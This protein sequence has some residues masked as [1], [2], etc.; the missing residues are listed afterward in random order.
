MIA[1]LP[2][3]L[4]EMLAVAPATFALLLA[5][6]G[7]GIVAA[8]VA[9]RRQRRRRPWQGWATRPELRRAGLLAPRGI[10]LGRWGRDGPLL[11]VGGSTH[12]FL[13]APTRAGKGAGFV[14]PNLLDWPGSVVVLDLKG[15][16]YAASAGFRA[17]HG[18]QLVLFD[19]ESPL[20]RR[21]N[22]LPVAADA[23]ARVRDLQR[24]A[25]SLYD[26]RAPAEAFWTHQARELFVGAALMALET[27]GEGASLGQ[28]QRFLATPDLAESIHQTLPPGGAGPVTEACARRLRQWADSG[29]ESMRAGILASAGERLQ[30]WSEPLLDRATAGSDFCLADLRRRPMAVYLRVAPA[31]L[32]RLAP[33]LRLFLDQLVH[34]NTGTPFGRETGNPV[35]VLLLLDEFPALGRVPAV[36]GAI[37]FMASFGLRCCLVAQS[38]SQL[39]GAYGE[40]GAAT[41]IRNCAS[42]IYLAPEG[43]EE[44][45]A[46]SA[47]LGSIRAPQETRTRPAAGLG[48]SSLSVTLVDRP[49]LPAHA[50]RAMARDAAILLVPGCRPIR[51][52]RIHWW[53]DDAFRRRRLPVPPRE[54]PAWRS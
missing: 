17:R 22:P 19:P 6:L 5:T 29:S 48:R 47:A 31:A 44:A 9:R 39:H 28:V 53:R 7:G 4:P 14:I 27:R 38:E 11:R 20:S 18:H 34:A 36:E 2:E 41:L 43:M 13:A 52:A 51:A 8:G 33:L 32:L 35:P 24:L 23:A 46:L 42:R 16:N 21:W 1:G 26:V 3:M 10:I 30:L 45:T 54:S 40:H 37:A 12:V 25:A 50:A 15:E 49:L